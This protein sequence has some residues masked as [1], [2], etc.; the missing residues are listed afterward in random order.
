MRLLPW[1]KTQ[2]SARYASKADIELLVRQHPEIEDHDHAKRVTNR[3][4][5]QLLICPSRYGQSPDL[6]IV[7]VCVVCDK[8]MTRAMDRSAC[9]CTSTG[10]TTKFYDASGNVAQG[11]AYCSG[12]RY[13]IHWRACVRSIRKLLPLIMAA[14][15]HNFGPKLKRILCDVVEKL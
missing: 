9:R 15:L 10:N 8:P 2:P 11:W 1:R 14:D 13:D 5:S 7:V 6:A 12:G 4:W 3:I